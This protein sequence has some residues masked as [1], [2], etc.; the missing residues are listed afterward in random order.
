MNHEAILTV[1][2]DSKEEAMSLR[3]IAQAMGLKISSYTDQISV[4]RRLARSL[5]TLIKRG[6]VKCELRQGKVFPKLWIMPTGR[7]N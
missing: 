1:L 2:P 7:L 5:R 4:Q 3:Q 6:W